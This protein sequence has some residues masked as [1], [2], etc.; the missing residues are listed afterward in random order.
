MKKTYSIILSMLRVLLVIALSLPR[1]MAQAAS[2]A[3]AS[4]SPIYVSGTAPTGAPAIALAAAPTPY[5]FS[6]PANL[7]SGTT[8]FGK[9]TRTNYSNWYTADYNDSTWTGT[10]EVGWTINWNNWQYIIPELGTTALGYRDDSTS[11]F[12]RNTFTIPSYAG[13]SFSTGTLQLFADD[14]CEVSINGAA[15]TRGCGTRSITNLRSGSNLI[16]FH[17]IN[18]GWLGGL[19]YRLVVNFYQTDTTAPTITLNATSN[20]TT[21]QNYMLGGRKWFAPATISVTATATDNAGGVGMG[22]TYCRI[23][24]GGWTSIAGNTCTI[25]T[26]SA[27]PHTV[28]TFA[29]DALGNRSS[30]YSYLFGVDA[31]G[32][33]VTNITTAPGQDYTAP[34]GSRFFKFRSSVNVTAAAED[35]GSGVS[36]ITTWVNALNPINTTGSSTTRT[37]TTACGIVTFDAQGTDNVGNGGPKATSNLYFDCDAPYPPTAPATENTNHVSSGVASNFVNPSFTWSEAS[38]YIPHPSGVAGYQVA[39][40]KDANPAN[41]GNNYVSTIAPS[42]TPPSL[43]TGDD[44]SRFLFVRTKDN[45]G[46]LSNW[47]NLFEYV[48]DTTPPGAV[49]GITETHGTQDGVPQGTDNDP[50][51]TWTPPADTRPLT[52]DL[53]WKDAGGCGDTNINAFPAAKNVSIPSVSSATWSD[54][55]MTIAGAKCLQVFA[56]DQAGNRSS[57]YV[58]FTFIQSLTPPS[59]MIRDLSS[60][61]GASLGKAG[62]FTGADSSLK[63]VYGDNFAGTITIRVSTGTSDGQTVNEGMRFIDFPAMFGDPGERKDFGASGTYTTATYSHTYSVPLDATETGRYQVILT[64]VDGD[65][66]LATFELVREASA[67][68]ISN[69]TIDN[70]ALPGTYLVGDTLYHTNTSSGTLMVTVGA[71][72]PE[73]D[74]SNGFS[75][76]DSVVFPSLSTYGG[77]IDKTS[78]YSQ[79]WSPINFTASDDKAYEITAIDNFGNSSIKTFRIVT[80]SVGPAV[81]LTLPPSSDMVFNASWSANDPDVGTG[82]AG[83]GVDHYQVRLVSAGSSCDSIPIAP[84]IENGSTHKTSVEIADSGLNS[85]KL[86]VRAFDR[87]GNAGA[88]AENIPNI[89]TE[90]SY[91]PFNDQMVAMSEKGLS[92]NVQTLYFGKDHLGSVD[93]VVGQDGTI[94]AETRYEPFGQINWD[95]GYTASDKGFTGQRNDSYINLLD[96]GSR[97]YDP[98]LGR[99]IS[100]DTIIPSVGEGN[101]P[102][103]IGYV[104]QA[105]Y[106]PLTVS[107]S[108]KQFLDQLNWENRER[109]NNPRFKL[110]DV[111][112]NA[113]AFDRYAYTLN[114]PV[115]YND[116]SG[117]CV[118]DL[119]IIEGIG[120]VEISL[121]VIATVATVEATTPGRPEAF[122]Q[123]MVD[124][125]KQASQGLQALFAKGEYIPPGMTQDE[126][127]AYREAL[128]QHYK[129]KYGLGSTDNVPKSILDQIR[130]KIKEGKSPWKAANEADAPPEADDDD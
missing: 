116:P 92:S 81:T 6:T 119:C 93:V 83:S 44:G 51:F 85:P 91:Y 45:V 71:N 38:D 42:F 33:N 67:P 53:F 18:N 61:P 76:V 34:D 19:Q 35:S 122:A 22:T 79:T 2:P 55:R 40:T 15:L 127:N 86:C 41:I 112:T 74:A 73:P 8:T 54:L 130:D 65:S 104:P 21:A 56:V 123:N 99:F 27:G 95:S 28:E 24:G 110:P 58:T 36:S 16:A 39:F 30:S 31:I 113:L 126:R 98:A 11:Y 84:D 70:S 87:L 64:T 46:N 75:V 50:S 88:W 117:H 77:F 49:T 5:V 105:T 59:L 78:P 62:R 57:Q 69:I 97:W 128:H 101:S 103:S 29:D 120:L 43:I 102:N 72:E 118:W 106:S 52:Y 23:D 80:D 111:P 47:A 129:N 82:I 12:H 37:V 14:E 115:R 109:L 100:P 1:G 13:Y 90:I 20:P 68:V 63:V 7:P 3:K 60:D 125:G 10:T 66:I 4:L 25:S 108:E 89:V 114:N 26:S 48:F 94:V 32:P 9:W 124:L 96:Y 121:A 17:Q 107:Y